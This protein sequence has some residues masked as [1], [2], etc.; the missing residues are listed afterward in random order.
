MTATPLTRRNYAAA[1][2]GAAAL[3]ALAPATAYALP[4]GNTTA[5]TGCHYTDKDGY[6]IP[7][8]DGQSVI[9]DGKTV[10]CSG[11]T[12]T[13]SATKSGGVRPPRTPNLVATAR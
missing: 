3:F 12:I 6:D 9:V 2:L 4:P 1:L 10:T 8:D 11:G 7:I 13:V 5:N